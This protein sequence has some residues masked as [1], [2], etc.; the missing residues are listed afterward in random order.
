MGRELLKV[1]LNNNKF[2]KEKLDSHTAVTQLHI[3]GALAES[4]W[5]FVSP[6]CSEGLQGCMGLLWGYPK[7]S[8]CCFGLSERSLCPALFGKARFDSAEQ[9]EKCHQ[10][11]MWLQILSR[12]G[13][14]FSFSLHHCLGTPV[15]PW[16]QGCSW[17]SLGWGCSTGL[18]VP[19]GS[20][21]RDE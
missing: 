18:R 10:H 5:M 11:E 6:S 2:K 16:D 12:A 20:P 15:K 14:S 8:S 21:E 9:G 19:L 13:E 1:W 17:L 7:N 4:S 3:P